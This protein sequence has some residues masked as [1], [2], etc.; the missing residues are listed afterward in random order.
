MLGL[1]CKPLSVGYYSYSTAATNPADAAAAAC[2]TAWQIDSYQGISALKQSQSVRI[3]ILKC[4]KDVLVKVHACSVNPLD[5][6]MTKG[7]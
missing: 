3:P 2:V 6:W 7:E 5:V 1:F 4:S